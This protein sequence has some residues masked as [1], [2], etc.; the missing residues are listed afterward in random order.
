MPSRLSIFSSRISG[1]ALI[2]A[3]LAALLIEWQAQ[4]ILPAN[5]PGHEVDELLYDL[6]HGRV[7]PGD[8]LFLG[9]SVGRQ[10]ARTLLK[11]NP[12]AFVP[13]ASN[14]AI[15]TPGQFFIL[16]RYL[17]HHAPP[18][19]IILMM[20]HPLRGGL[21]GNYT[22]N[23]F[24]RGFLHWREIAEIAWTRRSLPFSLVMLGYKLFPSF[25][26]RQALQSQ[27]PWLD[28]ANP[29]SGRFDLAAPAS[30]HAAPSQHG[31]LDLIAEA[32]NRRRPE[33]D[34]SERYFL[35][36]ARL[37]E[38]LDVAWIYL[39]IPVP[40]SAAGLTAPTGLYGR[41]VQRV[42]ELSAGFPKMRA[43]AK[44]LT[45]PDSQFQDGIHLFPKFLPPVAEEHVRIL[46]SLGFPIATP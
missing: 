20:A 43:S 19:R 46:A 35:R 36:L 16:R 1:S 22:E 17:E 4:R 44:F 34:I 21:D 37:L 24:Q 27:I 26:Y 10:I 32:W 23:Y 2:W 40:E 39:P 42:G 6:D 25:R 28:K 9:D 8:T 33:P 41:Q 18:R 45:Y 5:F 11:Q 14:A 29:Q 30:Q 31:L 38:S 7:P 12:E 13:L 15:E 3:V